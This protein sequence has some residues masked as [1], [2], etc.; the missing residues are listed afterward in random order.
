MMMMW[1]VSDIAIFVLKRDVKLQLT[2]HDDVAVQSVRGRRLRRAVRQRGRMRKSG[3]WKMSSLSTTSR[4][5]P[6]ERFWRYSVVSL[7]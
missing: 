1:L 4:P 6:S 7:S 3:R 5:F 2:N